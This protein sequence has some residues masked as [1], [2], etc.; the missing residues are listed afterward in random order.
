MLF[1]WFACSDWSCGAF[2]RNQDGCFLLFIMVARQLF[3]WV[4]KGSDVHCSASLV[5]VSTSTFSRNCSRRN[6]TMIASFSAFGNTFRQRWKSRIIPYTPVNCGA[7]TK[8]SLLRPR[9]ASV[10]EQSGYSWGLMCEISKHTSSCT[11]HTF[12]VRLISKLA[13]R[14]L[15]SLIGIGFA[16]A[17]VL[18]FMETVNINCH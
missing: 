4:G 6:D 2:A 13:G 11:S 15:F 10:L 7:C 3:Q 14:H 17:N 9:F 1:W 12:H 16:H 5:R 18:L 8:C